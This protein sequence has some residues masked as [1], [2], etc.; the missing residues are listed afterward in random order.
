[1]HLPC[2]VLILILVGD[3]NNYFLQIP[4]F[5]LDWDNKIY[6]LQNKIPTMGALERDVF[7]GLLRQLLLQLPYISSGM[8][9]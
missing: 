2:A 1:M 8:S 7:S 9:H 6:I 4:M 3:V 5:N